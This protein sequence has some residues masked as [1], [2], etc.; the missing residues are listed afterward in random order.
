MAEE[1][2]DLLVLVGATASGK[3]QV[4]LE[5]ARRVGGEIVSGDSMQVYRYMNVG[6][7]KPSLSDRALVPHHL[8]DTHFPDEE[9]S[10]A[11]YQRLAREAI[12]SVAARGRLPILAGGSWL[13]IRAVTDCYCFVEVET[14]WGM[15]E[16]LA[17][18]ARERG[19]AEL[20]R[21]LARVDPAT[22]AW[23]H[24]HDLRR[25]V[26][27][28]EVYHRTGRPISELQRSQPSAL[29]YRLTMIGLDVGR[30]E[31]YARIDARVDHMVR[32]GLREEVR[33]LLARGYSPSLRSMQ[34]LGYKEMAAHLMGR[35]TLEEAVSQIKRGTR[36]LARRQLIAFRRDRRIIWVQASVSPSAAVEGIEKFLEGKWNR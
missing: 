17:A 18:E 25:I 29:P 36:S 8:I 34:A 4:A 23:V 13:Y 7:A 5:L 15:R 6:T 1:G 30:P 3:S 27:A 33:A 9:F 26:R 28:L 31:L 32:A 20:H 10:V 2:G 19:T 24:P 12:S 22:A 16:A 35:T 14:D 21:R 11:A